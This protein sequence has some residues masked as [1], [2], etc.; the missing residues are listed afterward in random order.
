MTGFITWGAIGFLQV[1]GNDAA[2]Q[3]SS[4]GLSFIAMPVAATLDKNGI[5]WYIL[6]LVYLFLTGIT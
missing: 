6:F 4:V 2:S 5:S 1:K 3:T